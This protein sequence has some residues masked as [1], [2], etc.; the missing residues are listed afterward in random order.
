ML[1]TLEIKRFQIGQELEVSK[2]CQRCINEINSQD[3]TEKQVEN[4]FNAF[5]PRA[6][7]NYANQSHLYVAINLKGQICGTGTLAGNLVKGV[8][9][10]VKLIGTGIGRQIMTFLEKKAE[11]KGEKSI[12]LNSSK[13]AVKFYEKIGYKRINHVN[14][15]VRH[16]TKMEK[17]F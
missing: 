10:D 16:M 2:I 8:F 14:S 13:F 4:L 3:S 1:S 12:Y 11:E 7:L 5:T 17:R 15:R 9:V 6:I